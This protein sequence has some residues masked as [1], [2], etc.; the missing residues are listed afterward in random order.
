MKIKEFKEN[1][2]IEGFYLVKEKAL[3]DTK[4]GKKYIN[5]DICDN[6]GAVNAK[7]WDN[8]DNFSQCFEVGDVIK[9]VGKVG[10]YMGKMQLTISQLRASK[11][12]DNINISEFLPTTI[13]D[14]EDMLKE[15]TAILLSVKDDNI[16]KLMQVFLNDKDFIDKFKRSI[17]AK[18]MHHSFIGGLL[19]HT[20]SVVKICGSIANHY[21]KLNRDILLAIGFLHDI[22]KI[23]EL[24]TSFKF[25]YTLQGSLKGHLII[26]V[27][28]LREKIALLGNT[29]TEEL[30]SRLEHGIL[31]HH[32][33]YEWGAPVLPKTPEAMV[34]HYIDNMDAKTTQIFDEIDKYSVTPDIFTPYNKIFGRQ[35]YKN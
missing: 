29:F 13:Y 17:A 9:A 34:L 22:G 35:F 4:A 5:V 25:D 33:E 6:T 16:K 19:E 27:E 23:Y 14:I 15:L 18:S 10:K 2:N 26:G 3:L 24:E 20:L 1:Q 21:K 28:I 11:P 8:A 7:V 31:S 12:E 32:G 30:T